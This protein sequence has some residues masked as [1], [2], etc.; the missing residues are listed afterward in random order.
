[1]GNLGLRADAQED[2]RE[3]LDDI[4]REVEHLY[5]LRDQ[6]IGRTMSA[7][8]AARYHALLRREQDVLAELAARRS[9]VETSTASDP[10]VIDLR[11]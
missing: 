9:D 6:M 3:E 2:L 10:T 7:P 4:R 5:R 11:G 1:M 8:Q